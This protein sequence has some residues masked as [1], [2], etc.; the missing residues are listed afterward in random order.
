MRNSNNTKMFSVFLAVTVILSAAALYY[1]DKTMKYER[2]IAHMSDRAFSDIITSVN[3][4]ANSLN[5]MQYAGEGPYMN[6]LAANVWREALGAKAS[7]ALLPL[8]DV[9]L[10]ETQKFIS[11]SGAYAYSILQRGLSDDTYSNISSLSGT[12]DVLTNKLWD[13]KTKLNNGE[14]Q[15]DLIPTDAESGYTPMAGS[16]S[17]IETDFPEM[18]TLIYDGPFSAH[19]EKMKPQLLTGQAEVSR[20]TALAHAISFSGDD[21]LSYSH[22]MGGK[23]PVYVFTSRNSTVQV[24][25]QGGFIVNMS[26]N[27]GTANVNMSAEAAVKSAHDFLVKNGYKNMSESYYQIYGGVC[28]IN[29]SY[30]ENGIKVYPDLIKVSVSL[31]NGEV[32][33]FESMGYIMSHKDREL[34]RPALSLSEAQAKLSSSFTVIDNSMAIVPTSGENEVF[35]Y[36]FLCKAD[37][38]SKILVYI[39][40]MT[41]KEENM[42]ILMEDENGTLT[43]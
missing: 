24:T 2:Y 13:V 21:F 18:G 31:E 16:I 5:K 33:G 25:K 6:T 30:A 8:S 43:I 20:E 38:D 14:I 17:D 23:V 4:V 32:V 29:F 41:G 1:S 9:E 7:L 12:A 34:K 35:C 22:D 42:L 3:T 28:T 15:F 37:D 27:V 19:I 11:Q 10:D 36:E 40:A 39:D 26:K